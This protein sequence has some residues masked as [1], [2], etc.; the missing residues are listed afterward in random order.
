VPWNAVVTNLNFRLARADGAAVWVNGQEV[1][2]TNLPSGPITYNNVALARMTGF[3]AHV[4][5]PTNLAMAG[6]PTGTNL[7]AVEVH[8]SSVTNTTLGFDME[9]IGGG[10]LLPPSLRSRWRTTKLCSVG[11]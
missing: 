5:Y 6:L 11:P 3:T 7:V 4:F 8:L 9:L 10:Y 2:R 1:F